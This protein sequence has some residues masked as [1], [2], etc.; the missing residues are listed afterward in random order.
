MQ[1]LVSVTE[2]LCHERRGMGYPLQVVMA[3]LRFIG[4][5]GNVVERGAGGR[6]GPRTDPRR[7][8]PALARRAEPPEL[9]A[10]SGRRRGRRVGPRRTWIAWPCRTACTWWRAP[11]VTTCRSLDGRIRR[12]L[13][14]GAVL[15]LHALQGPRAAA[16]CSRGSSRPPRPRATS[17]QPS[18]RRLRPPSTSSWI[19]CRY[20]SPNG[21]STVDCKGGGP[22]AVLVRSGEDRDV[23][24]IADISAAPGQPRASCAGAQ[25]GLHRPRH[26]QETAPG[27]PGASGPPRS[28]VPGQRGKPPAGGL[29]VCV[30]HLGTWFIE[31]AGDRDPSGAR[32]GAMLQLM[33]SRHSGEAPPGIRGWLA[34]L[35]APATDPGQRREPDAGGPDDPPLK[36]CTLPLPPLSAAEVI[37]W[38]GDYF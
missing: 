13:G 24:A 31:D 1:R 28:G 20:R 36:D 35:A 15:H 2:L 5:V 29:L 8:L 12:V 38:H 34:A 6:R 3:P 27:R 11:S 9:R 22:P 7:Y 21:A 19:S 26:R 23:P 37:F 33:L 30:S 10:S 18:S 32:L 16:S 4:D 25:R 17:S 14:I